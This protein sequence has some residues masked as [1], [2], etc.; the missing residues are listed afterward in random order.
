MTCVDR[1]SR[2]VSHDCGR[3]AAPA[4]CGLRPVPQLAD[5]AR[6]RNVVQGHRAHSDW[7]CYS[8]A[9][10]R[11]H[12]WTGL[13]EPSSLPLSGSCPS[14]TGPPLDHPGR[15]ACRPSTSPTSTA[16]SRCAGSASWF[17]VAGIAVVKI[18]TSLFAGELLRRT[19]RVDRPQRTHRPHADLRRTPPPQGAHRV[20]RALQ[21]AATASSA[22]LAST[23]PRSPVAQL[24]LDR[25]RLDRSSVD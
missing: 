18:F 11:D 22:A 14:A 25:I 2:A 4:L 16:R 12:A 21:H 23:R 13:T 1:R 6:P 17:V 3:V 10:T 24:V 9:T 5:A 7:S 19:P 15:H 8:A 20:H